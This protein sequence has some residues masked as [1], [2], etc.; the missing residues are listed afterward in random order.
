MTRP[1]TAEAD[2][3]VWPTAHSGWH[4][5]DRADFE[6]GATSFLARGAERHERLMFVV[7]DP[8]PHSWPAHL[9]DQGQ[10]LIASTTEI[11]G[12]GRTVN[13]ASQRATFEGV[14]ADALR[15][16][17]SGL[18]VVADNT[19]LVVGPERLAAWMGWESEAQRFMSEN[20]VTGM[21]GFDGSRVDAALASVLAGAHRVMVDSRQ[22]HGTPLT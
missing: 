20:P 10:L 4:F 5:S 8:R 14:L 12:T 3:R 1:S 22:D 16:G 19:S 13:P 17:Y 7:D 15:E 11:Y 18:R 21:C 2:G 9:V 6:G